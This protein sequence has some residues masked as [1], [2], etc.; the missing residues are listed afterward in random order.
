MGGSSGHKLQINKI[1]VHKIIGF[2]V[3]LFVVVF[4][5]VFLFFFFLFFLFFWGGGDNLG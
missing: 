1:A 3:C 2:R 4:V 5:F